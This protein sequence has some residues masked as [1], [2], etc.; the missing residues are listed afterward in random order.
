VVAPVFR[1]EVAPA[2]SC[3]WGSGPLLVALLSSWLKSIPVLWLS[4]ASGRDSQGL[5][6]CNCWVSA[7]VLR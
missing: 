6:V 2:S 3:D 1:T 5:D 7:G 4:L